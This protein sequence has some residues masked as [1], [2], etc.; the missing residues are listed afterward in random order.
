M[1][2]PQRLYAAVARAH[3]TPPVGIQL[4]GFAGRDP[5]VGIGDELTATAVVLRDG[6]TKVAIVALD[7]IFLQAAYVQRVCAEIERRTRLPAGNVLLC[8]SHTHYG[9]ETAGYEG[10]P[11]TSDQAAYMADLR[12]QI[13]GAV[14]EANA[15]LKPARALLGRGSSEIGVNRRE[16]RPDGAIIL[17]QNPTGFID[18]ELIVLRLERPSGEPLAVLANFP[19]HGVSQSHLGRLISADFPGPMREV[20]EAATGATALY[21]QGAC[22]NINPIR[23]IEGLE[24]PRTLGTMLGAAAV[25]A[26]ESA[27]PIAATPIRVAAKQAKLP[28]QRPASLEEAREAVAALEGE[29]AQLTASK[30]HQGSRQWAEW[31]LSRAR[32]QLESSETGKPLPPVVADLTAIG[33][34]DLGIAAAPGEIFCEI[35]CAVRGA[36]PFPHTMFLGYT[37]GSI[38]YVPIPEAYP[39]GGYE[40]THASRVGPEAAGIVTDTAA[41][42]LRKVRGRGKG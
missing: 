9:P 25:L 42:L 6:Q 8:C 32:A 26:Y 3:I 41:G 10:D 18:R 39:E 17:G 37:N 40:V 30:A 7:L 4:C 1:P 28:A 15:N 35:G 16:R 22:G 31:R 29:L 14:Q 13:A 5:S 36:S 33:M 12:F 21:L 34:G 38:G 19:C 11:A 20:V 23:M 2:R 24:T 27:V